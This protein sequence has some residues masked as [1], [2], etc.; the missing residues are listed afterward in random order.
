MQTQEHVNEGQADL[1]DQ[2]QFIRDLFALWG[3]VAT[4]GPGRIERHAF[5]A[6]WFLDPLRMPECH[7]ARAA[8]LYEDITRWPE[9]IIR[10][11]QEMVR[12]DFDLH[13]FLVAPDPHDREPGFAGHVLLV[14]RPSQLSSAILVSTFDQAVAGGQVL[15]G[16][17]LSSQE[18]SLGRPLS[19]RPIETIY[20]RNGI[21]TIS[22]QCGLGVINYNHIN[23]LTLHMGKDCRL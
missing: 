20:V 17:L 11:W 5:V 22:V 7:L 9:E 15:S 21:Y 14:Q 8:S 19:L 23:R 10:V 2:P 13:I 3:P 1:T 4:L 12:P 18:E 16:L 6:V